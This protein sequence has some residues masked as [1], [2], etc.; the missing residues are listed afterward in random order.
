MKK[1]LTILAVALLACTTVFAVSF[2]GSLTAG[3]ELNYNDH[4]SVE[5][6]GDDGNSTDAASL[7]LGVADENG[8]WSINFNTIGNFD[9]S[10][11]WGADLTIG[12]SE[13]LNAAFGTTLP[14]DIDLSTVYNDRYTTLRAYNNASGNNVDRVRTVGGTTHFVAQV[15]Y[16]NYVTV[17]G[18][19]NANIGPVN[20]MA[21]SA[22]SA[23]IEGLKVS[24]DY[25]H[26]AENKKADWNLYEL[27]EI[28]PETKE[29]ETITSK[30]VV[31][32]AIDVNLGSLLGLD[33]NVGVSASERYQLDDKLN[34]TAATIYGGVDL[35]SGYVEY[36]FQKLDKEDAQHYLEAGVTVDLDVVDVKAWFGA[37]NL[38]N[39][40][41]TYYVGA[42][43]GTSFGGL[44]YSVIVE[45]AGDEI[46]GAYNQF[47]KAGFTI[48][49]NV[50]VSF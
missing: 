39:F 6:Y 21:V 38:E 24:V 27:K 36:A 20:S 22:L 42:S 33:F 5:Y 40:S 12:F 1:I 35:V 10:G 7:K 43:V 15:A 13:A 19:W 9:A 28:D 45:Y 47:G 48:T 4:W 41:K 3:A 23:P 49:P 50:S 31:G 16:E 46:S 25:A 32:A 44:D 11:A 30:D 26:G 37:D 17:A 18:A 34:T 14:V 2:S 29:K 8:L